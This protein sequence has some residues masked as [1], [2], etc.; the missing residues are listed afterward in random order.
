MKFVTFLPTHTYFP[1]IYFLYHPPQNLCHLWFPLCP[2]Q[3][4]LKVYLFCFC[5]VCCFYQFISI[6]QTFK[7]PLL[8]VG[9]YV[10]T[11]ENT[12]IN[13][14]KV[15]DVK[16][17]ESCFTFLNFDS[18]SVNRKKSYFV[19]IEWEH[20]LK[21]TS[22]S[23]IYGGGINKDEMLVLTLSSHSSLRISKFRNWHQR[24][25]LIWLQPTK[26]S[27]F[28]LLPFLPSPKDSLLFFLFTFCSTLTFPSIIPSLWHILQQ[29]LSYD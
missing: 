21:C 16:S 25:W 20:I 5:N 29:P 4:V 12:K 22:Q 26:L 24:S 10:K 6:H 19:R 7:G 9:N 1:F 2:F 11:L 13:Y 15:F 3:L 8:C 28:I 14:S 18:L 17:W 27:K 23:L